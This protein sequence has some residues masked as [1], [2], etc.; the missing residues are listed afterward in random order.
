MSFLLSCFGYSQTQRQRAEITKNYDLKKLAELKKEFSE[1]HK[2]NR[3]RAYQ[4]AKLRGV[5]TSYYTADSSYAEL[6]GITDDGLLLFYKTDNADAAIS[7]RTI[8]L[9]SGGGLGLSL[10]GQN[11]TAY[12]WDGGHARITHQEF[13]TDGPGGNDSKVILSDVVEEGGLNVRDHATHVIGTICAE[14][15]NPVA[16]GMANH[17]EVRSYRWTNDIAEVL[18]EAS[19]G[20]LLSNHSYGWDESG[21]AANY[22]G[23]YTY[24]SY[25]WDVVLYHAPYYLM[26]ASA[27]NK[28]N[29]IINDSPLDP[30]NPEYDKLRDHGMVKNNLVVANAQD[31]NITNNG[32]LI[33]VN[34]HATGNDASSQ[35]PTDDLRIKPDIAGN[36]FEVNS[37]K[38]TGDTDYEVRTGTSMAAP[39]VTGS[40]LLL[41]QHYNEINNVFMRSSTL[42][43]LALHTADDAGMIGPDAN[44]G[45][46]LLNAKKAAETI[47]DRGTFS[48]IEEIV[49]SQGQTYSMTVN[50]DGA[51]DLLA[52]ISWTDLPGTYSLNLND[53]TPV[54]VNDLDIK[55]T[56]N[57]NSNIFHPWRLTGV[58]TN[59]NDADNTV[60]NFERVDITNSPSGSYTIE[61]THKG[62]LANQSQ[63]FSLIVTG[64]SNV[65]S[66][67]SAP[68][69]VKISEIGISSVDVEWN[70]SVSSPINGYDIYYNTSGAIPD[71]TMTP[72]TSVLAGITNLSLSS[73]TAD[74][75]YFLYV[76]SNCGT[77]NESEWT[78]VT[79]FSTLCYATTFPYS[80]N[81]NLS[82]NLPDCWRQSRLDQNSINNSCGINDSNYLRLYGSYHFVD[83]PLV[84]VSGELEI[85]INFDIRNG[86]LDI[87]EATQ[88]LEI[89]YY[90][91]S[92]WILLDIIDPVDL[93]QFWVHKSYSLNT[94]LNNI[95]RIRFQRKGGSLDLDDI[96]IDNFE[97]RTPTPAPLN[98]NACDAIALTVNPSSSSGDTYSL[99]SATAEVGEPDTNLDSGVDGSVWFSFVAPNSGN[100]RIST[101]HIGA[102]SDDLELAVYSTTDCNDFTSFSQIGFDQD[103]GRN[104]NIGHM[105]VLDLLGLNSG[106]T[107]FIQVDRRPDSSSSTFGIE[108]MDLSFTYDDVNGFLPIDPS[109]KDLS[110]LEGD[111]IGGTLEIIDGTANISNTTGFNETIVNAKAVLDLDA[112]YTSDIIFKSD[113]SGSGQLAEASS[114]EI[115]G[116]IIVERYISATN[117]AFRFL[118]SSVNT[119]GTIRENWQQNGLNP[120]DVGFESNIGTHITG[121]VNGNNGFDA[122]QTGNPSM[123]T[124]DNSITGN[125]NSAWS[126]ISN[127]DTNTIAVGTPYLIFIRG[128]RNIDLTEDNSPPTPTT[129]IAE[130]DLFLGTHNSQALSQVNDYFSLVANPYQAVIDFDLVT[131]N[132][133]KSDVIVY[134]PSIG[135]IG[136]YETLTNNRFI[137]PGQSFFVQNDDDVTN[138]SGGASIIF[139]EADKATSGTSGTVVFSDQNLSSL[140]LGIYNE[141]QIRLD[142]M[143]FIF[144]SGGN[145]A[146]GNDDMGKLFA[147]T[148]NICS[149]NSNT[150]LSVE[151]RDLPQHDEV[152]PINVSQYQGNHYEFRVNLDNW[153]ENI[154]IFLVDTYLETKNLITENQ[155]YHFTVDQSVPESIVSDRFNVEFKNSNLNISEINFFKDLKIYPNPADKDFFKLQ[156]NGLS[157]LDITIEIFSTVGQKID[158]LEIIE[159]SDST[160][161]LSSQN[162]SPGI[163][164]V[165]LNTQ[166]KDFFGKLIVN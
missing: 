110:A 10:D 30:N 120:S 2:N 98:D 103:D 118:S 138:P 141:D 111:L 6:Q 73:L 139:E 12:V 42:K 100:V 128:D 144:Q 114:V 80:E 75:E 14:G 104:V 41:Q 121:D 97:I 69:N 109:G 16:K 95:F 166:G 137:K 156:L 134:N 26:V 152:I 77:N 8:Y 71:N 46:G 153:D 94:G 54:L 160:V 49:L 85:E 164:I 55:I 74:T 1:Y 93:S 5:E 9:N 99:K 81:F 36:G 28:G 142:V 57:S 125:Q 19:Q 165:K 72:T 11:M 7:T 157:N 15:T 140:N 48:I 102:K 50:S 66:F 131:K 44:F 129:L 51:N 70:S 37:T 126:Q 106:Q 101:D 132:N 122:T 149:V 21:L 84:D 18:E 87:S 35:G 3:E 130:G 24:L 148:E 32:D 65:S 150:F 86:C 89:Y 146:Y 43:G 133:I 159:K 47:T 88:N 107:Y 78:E 13:D 112:N 145:N 113:S 117:R 155:A 123:F 124:F 116:S 38:G 115:N 143:K 135:T 52:S 82:N 45:W 162:L 96:N 90:D 63:N 17:A 136:Q 151:R 161:T 29:T 147:S 163:Y 61:V 31:A 67:C 76:R 23:G 34:I 39:N 40:L 92:A 91:S 4:V 119:T 83:S 25:E 79:S 56:K 22:F 62:T 20:M 27:G 105:P 60:D 58:N 33:S 127:T 64:I 108:V 154:D 53:P 158:T 59:A 68:Q